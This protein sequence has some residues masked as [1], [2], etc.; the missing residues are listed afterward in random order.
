MP[1]FDVGLVGDC[2]AIQLGYLRR[3]VVADFLLVCERGH[4]IGS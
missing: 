4:R 3:N 2:A 1:D